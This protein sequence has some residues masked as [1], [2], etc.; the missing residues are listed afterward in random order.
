MPRELAEIVE[1]CGFHRPAIFP[2]DGRDGVA[3]QT[4]WKILFTTTARTDR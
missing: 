3:D 1:L 2:A 4:C